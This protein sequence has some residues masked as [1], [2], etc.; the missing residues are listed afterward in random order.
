MNQVETKK[1]TSEVKELILSK[2]KD[3]IA[4]RRHL[5]KHPELSLEEIETTK[6]LAEKLDEFGISYRLTEP[7]GIIAEIKGAGPGK[8]VLLRADMDALSV[9]QLNDVSYRSIEEGK[10]HACGHDTH[11]SMLLNAAYALNQVKDQFNGTVR[12]IFQPAEEIATGAKLMVEQGA[13]DGVDNAF[14]IHIWSGGKT[15]EVSCPAGPSF[16]AADVIRV[17]FTGRGGHAAQPH[18]NID[19]AIMASQ[20]VINAQSIV[21]R[22]VD[23][24]QPAVV[25]LGK[26]EVGTRFNV[27]AENAVIE[28]T[29]RTFDPETR[30]K[31]EASLKHYAQEIAQLYGGQAVVE[32]DRMT[33]PVNNEE[34]TAQ[35]VQ[36]VAA[37]AFGE[38]SVENLPPTMGGEDFG[39][40][41]TKIPGAFA[42]VGSGNAEKDT[43]WAHHSGRFNVDEDSLKVGAELYAQYA[44]AYLAQDAF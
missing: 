40:Y 3:M 5:H 23:P 1:L 11:V 42:T 38:E 15:G 35:L 9:Q 21:S 2:E 16:A 4:F 22:E 41:M 20:Y 28:G 7:T 19:A 27:V 43:F 31:V 25:T 18:L 33:E 32:Y 12:L 17:Y 29:I 6:A 10:M 44:L 24:L 30:D 39:Y 37:E 26:M 13:V 36:K 14:G 8:T 34:H